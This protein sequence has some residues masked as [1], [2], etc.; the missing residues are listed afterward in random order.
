MQR[1]IAR[2]TGLRH[3][4][5]D[6]VV[7]M[8][9]DDEL[10]PNYL[11]VFND[12]IVKNSREKVFYAGAEF[13]CRKTGKFLRNLLAAPFPM[14]TV[15]GEV[16]AWFK[17]GRITTGQ[18]IFHKDCLD[19]TGIYPDTNSYGEFAQLGGVPGYGDKEPNDR[20]DKPW[21][22]VMGNPYGDDFWLMYKLTR[23]YYAVPIAE[24][25]YKKWCR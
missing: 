10:L 22:E 19:K 2:N 17:S 1:L 14:S 13:F 5:G 15:E 18:F 20:H 23:D 6:W 9:D 11:Q 4:N 25:V 3:M 21:V 12:N 24:I 7:F 8:D 16:H